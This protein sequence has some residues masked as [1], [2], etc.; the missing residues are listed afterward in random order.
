MYLLFQVIEIDEDDLK[1]SFLRQHGQYF[2]FPVVPDISWVKTK[3]VSKLTVD[4]SRRSK[5][6]FKDY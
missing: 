5:Y 4:Q 3:E 6:T 1:V 2:M